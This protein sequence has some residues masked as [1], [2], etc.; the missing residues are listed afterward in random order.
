MENISQRLPQWSPPY[1]FQ[2]NYL[3]NMNPLSRPIPQVNVTEW[4]NFRPWHMVKESHKLASE[5]TMLKGSLAH[6]EF[7]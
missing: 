2:I 5:I 1:F 7:D 4:K 6:V 3:E